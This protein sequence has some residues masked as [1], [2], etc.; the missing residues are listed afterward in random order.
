MIR[1]IELIYA[2]FEMCYEVNGKAY[3]LHK[4]A[5]DTND[6]DLEIEAIYLN[7][8]ADAAEKILQQF[9]LMNDYEKYCDKRDKGKPHHELLLKAK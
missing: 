4:K 8:K 1:K 5:Y 7:G 6:K 3:D 9:G 2:L